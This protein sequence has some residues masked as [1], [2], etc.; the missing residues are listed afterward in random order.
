MRRKELAYWLTLIG[1]LTAAFTLAWY[2]TQMPKPP[3]LPDNL[4]YQAELDGV[5]KTS[6][7]G[8]D[9]QAEVATS[10]LKAV[11]EAQ[12]LAITGQKVLDVEVRGNR[13]IVTV[14]LTHSFGKIKLK[15]SL[16]KS[17][18]SVTEAVPTK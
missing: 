13:A 18:W 14:L 15:V 17:L 4:V 7:L 12:G 6:D 8:N 16:S 1:G 9:D 5:A 3:P 2:G 10:Y 11:G